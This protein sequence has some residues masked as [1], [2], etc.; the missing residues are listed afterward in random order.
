M[1]NGSWRG[2]QRSRRGLLAEA[3]ATALLAA[4]AGPLWAAEKQAPMTIVVN[5]SPW[6]DGFRAA[7]DAYQKET[8]NQVTLDVNSFAGSLEKQRAAVRAEQSPFDV[9]VMNAGFFIEMYVGGFL[10]PLTTVDSG[11][12]LDPEV[13]TFDDSV[14]WN[15]E[16]KRVDKAGQLMSV[17]INP[18]IPLLFYRAD[19]YKEKGLKV[20][21][22][23]DELLANAK[24]LNEPPKRYGIVQRGARG[25]FDV[26]YDV[27]P[28]L[29]SNGGDIFKDQ[30]GGDF[31]ITINSKET[32]AGLDV[33]LT[34]EKDAGHPKTAGQSQAN[35]IQ[36]MVTGKAGHIVSVIAAWPQMDDPNK[37]IVVDKVDYAP[38]PHGPGYKTSPP[39]GHWLGGIPKNIPAERQKAALAFLDWFQSRDAQMT[40]AKVGAPPVRKDVLESDLAKEQE[41]RWMKALAEALPYSR[42][43]FTI[44]EASEVLAITELR[45]NQAIGGELSAPKALNTMAAEIEVV[46]KKAGYDAPR[47]PDLPV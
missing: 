13:Y 22:T 5:Q 27:F 34:L 33:Y 6:F 12:K 11:F 3:G 47:L 15:P 28:Y 8:G 9:L 37:S 10:V 40:Y 39:L 18:N 21:E 31:T 45:L 36:S 30:K 25:T 14:F 43:T 35:V 23:W 16:T 41:F 32:L 29:W 38:P 17:P 4:T 44:P 20:P 7:V 26:T 24:A 1:K 42:L 19:L 2:G 46:M